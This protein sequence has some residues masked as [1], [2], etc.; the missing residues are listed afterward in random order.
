MVLHYCF[1]SWLS[2]VHDT[3]VLGSDNHQNCWQNWVNTGKYFEVQ[4]SVLPSCRNWGVKC[5]RAFL[6][7]LIRETFPDQKESS[8]VHPKP[9][10]MNSLLF[11]FPLSQVK[12]QFITCF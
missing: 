10:Q 2:A 9:E 3:Y 6:N 1:Y 11:E 8:R 4:D 5:Q 7:E 12:P